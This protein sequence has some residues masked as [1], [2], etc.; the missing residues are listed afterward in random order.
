MKWV[1]L[2]SSLSLDQVNAMEA[3]LLQGGFRLRRGLVPGPPAMRV[4]SVR[5]HDHARAA[6]LLTDAG[7]PVDEDAPRPVA[8]PPRGSESVA[9]R[10]W[11]ACSLFWLLQG[12]LQSFAPAI[13][14]RWIDA[15]AFSPRLVHELHRFFTSAF[16]HGSLHH[17][18][19]NAIAAGLLG[20]PLWT[21]RGARFT[22]MTAVLGALGGNLA[23]WMWS[24]PSTR[25][26]GA[27]SMIAAWIGVWLIDAVVI[28]RDDP[29]HRRLVAGIGGIAFWFLPGLFAAE[30]ASGAPVSVAGHVGGLLTGILV[31]TASALL[32]WIRLNRLRTR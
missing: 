1:H 18:G 15:G 12:T 17:A 24:S 7:F 8:P 21:R 13:G 2:T 31:G 25:V 28:L 14:R 23:V 32:S 4:I 5:R 26:V 9:L 20:V 10:L 22:L 11:A 30:S 6:A 29:R 27:S 19:G 16:L 3:L